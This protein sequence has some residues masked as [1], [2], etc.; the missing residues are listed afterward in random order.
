MK[1]K[2]LTE[3]LANKKVVSSC[4]AIALAAVIGGVSLFS[5]V[6]ETPEFPS[7]TDPIMETSI[8]EDETPLASQPKTTVKTTSSTKTI[9]KTVKL[10][11][12]F[13]EELHQETENQN[14]SNQ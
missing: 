9:R 14:K 12:G 10:K 6:G 5:G 11:K 1:G 13:Q 4:A 3:W 7:Y 2:K 8:I